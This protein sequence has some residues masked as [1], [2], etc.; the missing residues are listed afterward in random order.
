[1][2]CCREGPNS[3]CCGEATC[4][5][6]GGLS[7]EAQEWLEVITD[8]DGAEVQEGAWKI[9]GELVDAGLVTLGSAR[10]PEAAWR[11]AKLI[12]VD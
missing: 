11:R 5:V 2:A 4:V 6:Q 1:M 8:C 7:E 3:G 12:E 9:V 10:G